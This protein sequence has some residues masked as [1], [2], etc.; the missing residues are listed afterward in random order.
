MSASGV[1]PG[2]PTVPQP[3]L[4]LRKAGL[5]FWSSVSPGKLMGPSALSFKLT[6]PALRDLPKQGPDQGPACTCRL[7]RNP[8]PSFP[9][10][11]S[12]TRA[13]PTMHLSATATHLSTS[14]RDGG[15]R[16][17]FC[18]RHVQPLGKTERAIEPQEQGRKVSSWAGS[19]S[20]L[21]PSL[22]LP[23]HL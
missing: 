11:L 4:Q 12:P 1:P 10:H 21:V 20:P 18:S 22:R 14:S 16:P 5:E 23:P 9:Q 8:T 15:D 13:V 2:D 7:L 6:Q 3:L 19:M 17:S